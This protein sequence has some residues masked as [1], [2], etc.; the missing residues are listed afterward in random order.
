MPLGCQGV[1]RQQLM[2]FV[3]LMQDMHQAMAGLNDFLEPGDPDLDNF[4]PPKKWFKP[5]TLEKVMD[6]LTKR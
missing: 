4:K 5:P 2:S 6:E 3:D 1:S